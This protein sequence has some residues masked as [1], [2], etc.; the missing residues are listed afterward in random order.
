[1]KITEIK[2]TVQNSS[3]S[4]IL[5]FAYHNNKTYFTMQ[6][7]LLL[8]WC[9]ETVET[10]KLEHKL[11]NQRAGSH[12]EEATLYSSVFEANSDKTKRA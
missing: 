6:Y 12:G 10:L 4:K 2:T 7:V 9:E 1:M 3:S 8:C 5:L 11:G